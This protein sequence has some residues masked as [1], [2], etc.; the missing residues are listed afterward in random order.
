M[1]PRAGEVSE[2]PGTSPTQVARGHT[3]E[4]RSRGRPSPSSTAGPERPLEFRGVFARF[5]YGSE[6]VPRRVADLIGDSATNLRQ[7]FHSDRLPGLFETTWSVGSGFGWL[8]RGICT[9]L[10]RILQ[11]WALLIAIQGTIGFF[12]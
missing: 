6:A 9:V 12:V 4:C 2:C 10:P 11:A 8:A 7:L 1:L 5:L 3:R